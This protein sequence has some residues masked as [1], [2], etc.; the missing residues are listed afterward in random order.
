MKHKLA[1]LR[2]LKDRKVAQAA[3]A[4]AAFVASGSALA[5]V[6]AGVTTALSDALVDVG[7]VGSAV[8]LIVVAIAV[9]RYLKRTT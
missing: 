4:V 7:V 9:W 2:A 3:A 6:P 1:A 5:E 8:F